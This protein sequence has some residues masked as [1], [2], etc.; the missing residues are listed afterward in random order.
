M[1]QFWVSPNCKLVECVITAS[2]SSTPSKST[3]GTEKDLQGKKIVALETF[4][5]QDVPWSPITPTNQVIEGMAFTTAF[6]TLYRASTPA[7]KPSARYPFGL[8]SQ[9]EGLYYDQ[10]PLCALRRVMNLNQSTAALV[11]PSAFTPFFIEPTEL[12][13]TKCYV[14]YQPST[15]LPL[16]AVSA[17]FLVH[18]LNE[19]Q[20]WRPYTAGGG[21]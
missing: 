8:P 14:T 7:E 4:T 5:G 15:P 19:N 21:M 13:W 17:I 6:L 10:I 12:S 11:Q 16:T 18:Y 20:D 1:Q 2:N 9:N 3:F